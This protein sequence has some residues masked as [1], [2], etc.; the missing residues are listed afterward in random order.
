MHNASFSGIKDLF[1]PIPAGVETI[2][3]FFDEQKWMST[4]GKMSGSVQNGT[5]TVS[6]QNIPIDPF[7]LARYPVTNQLYR[8]VFPNALNG[9][10]DDAPVVQVSWMEAVRFCNR[11]SRMCG[12]RAC[13][14]STPDGAV[15]LN[16]HA[17][18]FR[19]PTDA[20]WQHACRAGSTGYRYG[21]LD[22]IAW[23]EANSGGYAHAVGQKTPNEWGLYDMLGNVWEWC[24][25]LF[26]ARTYGTYRIFRGGSWAESARGCGATSRRRGHPSFQMDDLGFRLAR[27]LPCT[28]SICPGT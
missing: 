16:E 19:L 9:K 24:W 14:A 5:R 22:E 13:Y 7:L 2:R 28:S 23:Y 21:D 8:T 4:D 27:S 10:G 26:D 18:G 6:E 11:L 3:F 12:F 1:V 15:L 25:D 20:E 17:N